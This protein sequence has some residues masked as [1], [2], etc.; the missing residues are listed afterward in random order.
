MSDGWVWLRC[1]G[2]GT[3]IRLLAFAAG[4]WGP[5]SAGIDTF[6]E[7][8][9]K[10]SK[11]KLVDVDAS[12]NGYSFFEILNEKDVD[13]ANQSFRKVNEI[14]RDPSLSH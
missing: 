1:L 8:H 4:D 13:V 11:T 9:T 5:W 12:A 3:P 10:C 14:I 7:H 2:C 6:I